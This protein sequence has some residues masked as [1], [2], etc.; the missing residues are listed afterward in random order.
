ML[1]FTCPGEL[2]DPFPTLRGHLV[3]LSPLLIALRRL[4]ANSSL[5]EAEAAKGGPV[6]HDLP[7]HWGR[8][9]IARSIVAIPV[10]HLV[11]VA[12]SMVGFGL[13]E[14]WGIGF[15]LL[16]RAG[17][18][19]P[20]NAFPFN[21][22]ELAEIMEKAAEWHAQNQGVNEDSRLVRQ[23][24]PYVGKVF[25]LMLR[26]FRQPDRVLTVRLALLF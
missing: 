26:T 11:L 12:N 22:T 7:Q 19:L 23:Q 10:V 16:G 25:H 14:Q 8:N 6:C 18:E 4:V 5:A 9:R 13:L 2:L 15:L 1:P 24:V 3:V 17:E 20:A 21:R